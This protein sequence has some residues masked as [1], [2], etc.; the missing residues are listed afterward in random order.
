MS[1]RLPPVRLATL[2]AA[3]L[4]L[5]SAGPVHAAA[6]LA[7]PAA[8]T[9]T[10]TARPAPA[11]DAAALQ[12]MIREDFEF[13]AAQY[14]GMLDALKDQPLLPRSSDKGQ[15]KLVK[16][17]DWTSGFF[18]GAL[19]LVYDFNRAPQW[20][21][22]AEAQ[23]AKLESV[24]HYAGDHDTGFMLGCSFGQGYRLTRNPA[25]RAVLLD[26]AQA[27]ST[28]FKPGAG[29]I[30]SWDFG[31]W[32]CPVIIDNM[33][34][35]ELLLWA[36]REGGAPRFRDIAVSHANK[37]LANHF[38]EDGSSFHLVDYDPE[39]GAILR[40]QTVQGYADPSAWARGQA[41]GLYGFTMLYRETRDP[42]YLAQA[43]RIA[44][45]VGKH[46]S[47]PDDKIPYW[48]FNAPDLPGAP[49]DTSAG[50][51]MASALLELC[52]HVPAAEA[53]TYEDLATSQLR[54]LSS[55]AYRAKLGENH[56]FLLLHGVGHIPGKHEIDVALIYGD[57]YFLEGLLRLK[58]RLERAH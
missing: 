43:R 9:P 56:G 22:A 16:P 13:A 30:R 50:A 17:D 52:D 41:W 32:R 25:Y 33:M 37:T 7:S 27:L 49:R 54:S 18:P 8:C 45:F 40:K 15:L 36:A 35:L 44:A 6:S 19:W 23:T 5:A 20:R 24:R 11:A 4:V 3:V 58:A 48:D 38:R 14:S 42:A 31:T 26:G 39:S 21:A 51:I 1:I 57:Y 2:S 29:I 34:N 55:P 47:L 10:V 46:P 12:A 53:A 28:R